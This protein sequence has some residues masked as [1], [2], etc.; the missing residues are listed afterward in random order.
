[1]PDTNTPSA[2]PPNARFPWTDEARQLV[3]DV[4]DAITDEE[5]GLELVGKSED[6]ART[7]LWRA[8]GPILQRF[9]RAHIIH[10]D[11]RR[12]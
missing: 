6:E 7:I 10:H 12:D 8:V 11:R 2:V 3:D 4:A 9:K 5:L 1:M